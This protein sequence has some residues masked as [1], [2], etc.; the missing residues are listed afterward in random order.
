MTLLQ[1]LRL[2]SSELDGKLIMDNEG[3]RHTK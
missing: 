1:L 2:H 3:V